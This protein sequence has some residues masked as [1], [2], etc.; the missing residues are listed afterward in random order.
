MQARQKENKGVQGE[1]NLK[2][3]QVWTW[4]AVNFKHCLVNVSLMNVS[5]IMRAETCGRS[6]QPGH[7]NRMRGL[8]HS[9]GAET[10][11]EALVNETN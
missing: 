10:E 11:K 8:L 5:G 9:T 1:S 3:R 4:E 2:K 6:S 7:R